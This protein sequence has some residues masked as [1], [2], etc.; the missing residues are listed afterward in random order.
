LEACGSAHDWATKLLALGHKVKIMALQFL[1]P[2]VKTNKHD[3]ADAEAIGKAISRPI[4][5]I[6]ADQN[7]GGPSS[8][9]SAP[10]PGGC[11]GKDGAG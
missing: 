4:V 3:A 6:C 7:G 5:A 8:I 9:V 10:W 2:C 1:R 11:Q